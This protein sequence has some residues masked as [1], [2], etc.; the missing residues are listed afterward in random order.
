MNWSWAKV[1][2]LGLVI[3]LCSLLPEAW[4]PRPLAVLIVLG[5]LLVVLM[6]DPTAMRSDYSGHRWMLR[7]HFE[8]MLAK[9]VVEY[10]VMIAR[11]VPK[12]ELSGM[13]CEIE[14][15]TAYL[16]KL[17]PRRYVGWTELDRDWA[18]RVLLSADKTLLAYVDQ[19]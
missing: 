18:D 15:A 2:W 19:Q 1:M 17:F 13:K 6:V 14:T 4:V 11:G 3:V 16:F 10:D 8:V 9:R 7:D 5:V 12:A